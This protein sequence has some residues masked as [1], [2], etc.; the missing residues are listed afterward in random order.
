MRSFYELR[1]EVLREEA[2]RDCTVGIATGCGEDSQGVEVR[3]PVGE[4]YFLHSIASG[5]VLGPTQ[6]PV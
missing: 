5:P 1:N 3:V 6:P 2:S 4:R